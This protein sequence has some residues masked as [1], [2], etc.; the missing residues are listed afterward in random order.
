[1]QTIDILDVTRLEPKRKHPTIFDKFDSLEPGQAFI[2]HNDHDPKPLYYQLLGERGTVFGW[3]YLE[4]GPEWW[5]VKISKIALQGAG[6]TVGEIAAKDYRK[7]EV[8]KR[9]GIDF[10]CGGNKTLTQA[11]AEAGVSDAELEAA[12]EAAGQ[13]PIAASE[14]YQTWEPDF[15]A[16]YIVNIHHRYVTEN[17]QPIAEL[18]EKVAGRHGVQHPELIEVAAG[19]A[20]M[21]REL[22]HHL[23]KEEMILFP[24]IRQLADA[25]RRGQRLGASPFGSVRSPIGVMQ[26]EHDIAG[27]DLAYLRRLTGGFQVPENA[28]NSYTY[29][30]A[31]LQEFESDLQKHVHLENN[32]L[33][34]KAVEL[35]AEVAI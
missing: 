16:D 8:F 2:I 19:F 11:S 1:M 28:C 25:R 34:P 26:L 3:E 13:Q 24:Y 9:L 29:L 27:E 31:K 32:I 12:L 17:L 15:L 7:A 30:Y 18:A 21:S 33:F 35:E 23:M 5:K 20:K 6:S 10:C 4:N 22:R 14:N